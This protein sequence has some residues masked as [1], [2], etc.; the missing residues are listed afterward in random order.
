MSLIVFLVDIISLI[1]GKVYQPYGLGM[2]DSCRGSRGN[3]G[4]G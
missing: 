4:C 3:V 2:N 1:N